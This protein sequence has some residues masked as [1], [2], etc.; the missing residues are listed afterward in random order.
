MAYLDG[1]VLFSDAQAITSTTASTSYIDFSIARDIGTGENLYI[2]TNVDVALVDAS[3]TDSTITVTLQ[4]SAGT[5]FTT[6]TDTVLY[7]VAASAAIGTIYQARINPGS[8]NLRYGQLKYTVNNGNLTA[9]SL[10]SGILHGIDK[11]AYYASG[12]A[13]L[14]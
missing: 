9:G 7:T 12:F 14:K 5:T 10:T 8:L 11:Q 4:A 3:G 6:S 13:V 2:Q 1:L